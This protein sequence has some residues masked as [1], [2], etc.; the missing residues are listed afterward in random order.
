LERSSVWASPEAA[1]PASISAWPRRRAIG[2]SADALLLA[3][4]TWPTPVRAA[5]ATTRPLE[6]AVDTILALA[7]TR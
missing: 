7:A 6:T 2:E 4:T 1:R 3:L 5:L